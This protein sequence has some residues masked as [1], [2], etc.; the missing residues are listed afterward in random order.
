MVH[1][2]TQGLSPT[3]D[4]DDDEEE[5]PEEE[6]EE[7][8]EVTLWSQAPIRLLC[9]KISQYK[10]EVEGGKPTVVTAPGG[11][12]VE[13]VSGSVTVTSG[14]VMTVTRGSKGKVTAERVMLTQQPGSD[15]EDDGEEDSVTIAFT[16][17]AGKREQRKATRPPDP[18]KPSR[19]T[20]F[21]SFTVEPGKLR[22]ASVLTGDG[23]REDPCGWGRRC[24]AAHRANDARAF[25][26]G[27]ASD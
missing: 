3:L 5:A 14:G 27:A 17:L 2:I 20:L 8:E 13:L 4:E 24:V 6:E 10:G 11:G 12:P 26:G 19:V 15:V 7:E 23:C 22:R 25:R 16:N 1:I 9:S 21:S 18:L